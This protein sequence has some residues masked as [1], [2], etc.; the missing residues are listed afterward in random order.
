MIGI[1]QHPCGLRMKRGDGSQ[2]LLS[3]KAVLISLSRSALRQWPTLFAATT[4]RTMSDRNLVRFVG[5][6][7]GLLPRFTRGGGGEA[8]PPSWE[9]V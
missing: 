5:G 1:E 9:G 4:I 2:S 7:R 3:G 6:G 8:P